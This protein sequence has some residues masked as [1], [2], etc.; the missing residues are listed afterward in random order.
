MKE[1]IIT[2]MDDLYDN[3]ENYN[4]VNIVNEVRSFSANCY[5]SLL[6]TFWKFN[7]ICSCFKNSKSIPFFLIF[8]FVNSNKNLQ[9]KT[10]NK[11]LKLKLEEYSKAM[12][13]LQKVRNL[14]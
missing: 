7:N 4:D 8:T 2:K 5:L 10:E 1:L 13:Q 6:F 11:E 14:K 12:V 9:L 3:L